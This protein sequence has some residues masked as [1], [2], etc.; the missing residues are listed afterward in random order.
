MF[1]FDLEEQEDLI[2][3]EIKFLPA[4]LH[5]FHPDSAN[6]R[7]HDVVMLKNAITM[8]FETNKMVFE[9]LRNVFLD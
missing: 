7:L 8:L 1:S 3:Q 5:V 2:N 6:S 4:S 9:M